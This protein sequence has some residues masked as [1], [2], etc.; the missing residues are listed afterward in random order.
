M[1]RD[2]AEP[3]TLPEM[4]FYLLTPVEQ[5]LLNFPLI[6]PFVLF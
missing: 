3:P 5:T 2:L 4:L 1:D 6:I